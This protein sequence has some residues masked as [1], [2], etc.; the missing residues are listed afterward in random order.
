MSNQTKT[1]LCEYH[2]DPVDRLS[3]QKTPGQTA[4]QHFYQGDHLAT[5]VQGP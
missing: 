2:H 5:E 3:A 4:T 1:I